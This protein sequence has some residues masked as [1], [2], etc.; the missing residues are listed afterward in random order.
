MNN[1]DEHTCNDDGDNETN[2]AECDHPIDLEAVRRGYRVARADFGLGRSGWLWPCVAVAVDAAFLLGDPIRLVPFCDSPDLSDRYEAV[3][4]RVWGELCSTLLDSVGEV[5]GRLT[6]SHAEVHQVLVDSVVEEFSDLL[7]D[8]DTELGGAFAN[9]VGPEFGVEL[10]I[11][12]ASPRGI[13]PEPWQ[14]R[15][16]APGIDWGRIHEMAGWIQRRV[17]ALPFAWTLGEE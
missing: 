6:V 16:G 14:E 10:D 9:I 3:G 13:D 12:V 8:P 17:N 7:E 15:P 2:G 11:D 5:E 1:R 4:A